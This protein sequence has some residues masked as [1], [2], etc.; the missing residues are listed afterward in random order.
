M[1]CLYNLTITCLV[2]VGF[3]VPITAAPAVVRSTQGR[4]VRWQQRGTRRAESIW[5]GWRDTAHWTECNTAI[6]PPGL[7]PWGAALQT[8][9]QNYIRSNCICEL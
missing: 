5:P 8:Q 2:Y 9:I 7:S 1:F 6:S 3:Y 4:L